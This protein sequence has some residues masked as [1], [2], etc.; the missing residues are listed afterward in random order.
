[1]SNNNDVQNKTVAPIHLINK[2]GK[3]SLTASSSSINDP[4][5]DWEIKNN[6]NQNK[7]NISTSSSGSMKSPT[8]PK[9]KKPKKPLFITTNRFEVLSQ[10]DDEVFA[11]TPQ[12]IIP[13]EVIPDELIKPPPPIFVRGVLEFKDLCNEIS[14]L[15][16]NDKFFC[17]SST[18]QLK[19]Q[20]ATPEAYRLLIHYLKNNNAQFH[21]YQLT[22]DKPIR[23]VIRN[24][25]PSTDINEIKKELTEL[26]FAVKQVTNVLHKTTKLPLPLFFVDLEKSEKSLEIFQLPS[27][28]YTKIKV[29]EPYKPRMISQCQNCQDYGH[30]RSYCGYPPRCVRCGN[31]HL[32]SDCTKPR[33]SP[34]KC[35]LCSG[36]HP[37]NYRGCNVFKELQRR[38]KPNNKSKFLHDNVNLNHYNNNNFNVKENH[39]LPTNINPNTHSPLKTYAQAT[40]NETYETTNT[41]H[42]KHHSSTLDI[43]KTMSDF[44]DNFKSLI[45]L[46]IALLTQV[47]SS[48]LNNKNDR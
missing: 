45:N 41:G 47:I 36:S 15:I 5:N 19:I 42:S 20:T 10:N 26:S 38:K 17:K 6:K 39:P 35:A 31:S 40:S 11:T 1:M 25:H 34:A 43:N 13:N 3:N 23:V 27:L 46:L 7:R 32:T 2:K 4:V 8:L 12:A 37:T 28:L 22:Q 14:E 24:I 33:D 30:T 48:L 21:T 44:L 18:D 9:N 16:G 29:E